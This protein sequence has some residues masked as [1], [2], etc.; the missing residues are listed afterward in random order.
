MARQSATNSSDVPGNDEVLDAVLAASRVLVA[1]AVRSLSAA[2]DDVTLPQYRALVVLAY[3]G[4]QRIIDLAEELVVNSSTATRMIDRLERRG[5]VHRLTHPEDRRATQLEI[6]EAGLAAVS[7]V[8]A[9]R[10]SEF[11]RILRKMPAAGRRQLVDSLEML[12]QSAGEA[13]EH[14]WSSGWGN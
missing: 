7:S 3:K 12:R 13:P 6:T 2:G 8:S 5:L 14:A 11:S 9:R 4:P 1:I 10:R